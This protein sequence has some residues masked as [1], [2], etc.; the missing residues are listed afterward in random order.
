MSDKECLIVCACAFIKVEQKK[1]RLWCA[2]VK[3]IIITPNL[4]AVPISKIPI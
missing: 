3:S 4:F 2:Q 1:N